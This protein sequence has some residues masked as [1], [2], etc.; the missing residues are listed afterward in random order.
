MKAVAMKGRNMDIPPAEH[1]LAK[2]AE[3]LIANEETEAARALLLCSLDIFE[4]PGV[5]PTGDWESAVN[6]RLQGPE[7]A[8]RIIGGIFHPMTH[9]LRSVILDALQGSLPVRFHVH[10]MLAFP[11]VNLDDPTWRSQLLERAHEVEEQT[12]KV[13]NQ[14]S[15]GYNSRIVTWNTL[16]F[17]SE[18]ERRIAAALEEAGVLFLPNCRVRLGPPNNRQ[19][20]EGDFLICHEGKWGILEV[21]GEP[22]H[23]P[24]RKAQ[25]D[26]RDRLFKLHGVRVVEHF[27]AKKCFETPTQVVKQFLAILKHS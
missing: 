11:G 1:V 12:S 23:P 21:D 25:E 20:R 8:C 9:P 17:R 4:A 19:N 16:R 15:E 3:W 2:T 6:I 10:R 13:D 14:G 18:T 27:D 7:E 5:E 26:E 22:Y 24:S